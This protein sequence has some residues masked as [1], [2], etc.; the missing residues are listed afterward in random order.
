[1]DKEKLAVFIDAENLTSWI[2]D[3]GL[4]KLL[5]DLGS[6]GQVIVRRAYGKWTNSNLKNLQ[7]ILNRN[8]FE[9]LHTYHPVK[10]KNSSDIQMTVDAMEYALK[11][12]DVGWFVLA[13]GDSDF[14]PLFRKLRE[15]GKDVIGV[16]PKSPLS[17]CV[18]TSCSRYIY[19]YQDKSLEKDVISFEKEEIE[20]LLETII[21][22]NDEPINI[23]TLK[24]RMLQI[25]SAF[26]EK[27]FGFKNFT[28]Y[29]ESIDFLKIEKD[30]VR[31]IKPID[32]KN[33]YKSL[34]KK[35]HWDQIP[36]NMIDKLYKEAV[37]I[38]PMPRQMIIEK[39]LSL[40]FE[41]TSS[42]LIK[43]LLGILYK[44]GLVEVQHNGDDEKIWQIIKENRYLEKIDIAMLSRLISALKETKNDIDKNILTGIC[45]GN[46]SEKEFD[47]IFQEANNNAIIRD[48]I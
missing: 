18:K 5:E 48:D 41:G 14:S 30:I 39:L 7:D 16:G 23:S 40:N 31:Y 4:T 33:L 32:N 1:M 34:L 10:G 42:T 2:K 3:D 24:N 27:R 8:G 13:T 35:K 20:E 45:Y 29:V 44:A 46:Y 37:R 19:T 15:I 25:D 9:L 11:L 28:S 12:N 21:S 47:K 36:K 43:K 22:N 26:N 6:L 38:N 17:E